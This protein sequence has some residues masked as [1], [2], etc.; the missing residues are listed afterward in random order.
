MRHNQ[1]RLETIQEQEN[2]TPLVVTLSSPKVIK[3]IPAYQLSVSEIEI[4]Y[5]VD[6]PSE[7]IVEAYTKQIGTI[8]LW[9]GDAYDAIGD[10]T[11][12][13][14]EAKIKDIYK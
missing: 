7:K 11:N 4:E 5:F 13:D 12:A 2:Q 14:V 8:V 9:E 1:R 3:E 10:W 6:S